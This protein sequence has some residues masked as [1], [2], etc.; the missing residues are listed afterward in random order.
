ML[1]FCVY[2]I[3]SDTGWKNCIWAEFKNSKKIWMTEYENNKRK[4]CMEFQTN[5]CFCTTINIFT[6]LHTFHPQLLS[7][8]HFT[9]IIF[10]LT[11]PFGSFISCLF[12]EHQVL[13]FQSKM[14]FFLRYW[15]FVYSFWTWNLISFD[16]E[17][18]KW[19]SFNGISTPY[20]RM[21]VLSLRVLN[22]LRNDWKK[23]NGS[24]DNRSQKFF[25]L[26]STK[27]LF[28]L[29]NSIEWKRILQKHWET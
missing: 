14:M 12:I 1:V 22:M 7:A 19:K 2:Y 29:N 4:Y 9:H 23:M 17:K 5:I 15:V 25:V 26:N 6:S 28:N 13:E 10:I 20:T 3:S 27:I 8:L 24:L 16:R 18:K 11:M 21:T